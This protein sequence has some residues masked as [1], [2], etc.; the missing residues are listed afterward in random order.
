[1][2]SVAVCIVADRDYKQTRLSIENLI[3]ESNGANIVL[4][5]IDCSEDSLNE[6][7]LKKIANCL[8]PINENPIKKNY[9]FKSYKNASKYKAYNEMFKMA[10]EDFICV[11]PLE[12]FVNKNWVIDLLNTSNNMNGWSGV[13]SINTGNDN[14]I[15]FVSMNHFL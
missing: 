2:K 1:M 7:Y 12:C 3:S 14:T 10:D 4:Y 9:Y 6:V 5:I 11:F 15:A 8:A 13:L